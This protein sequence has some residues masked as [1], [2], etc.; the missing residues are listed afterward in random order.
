MGTALLKYLVQH[1]VREGLS[2]VLNDERKDLDPTLDDYADWE[3]IGDIEGFYGL[4]PLECSKVIEGLEV[5]LETGKITY[6]D[7]KYKE[8][9]KKWIA[10]LK[11]LKEIVNELNK[12]EDFILDASNYGT[13]KRDLKEKFDKLNK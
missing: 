2:R 3:T 11:Y 13:I 6:A 9:Y 5:V 4:T 7:E 8:L 12:K 10:K 1:D